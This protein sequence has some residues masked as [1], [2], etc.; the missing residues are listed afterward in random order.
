MKLLLILSSL[1]IF[2][3]I[4]SRH[5]ISRIRTLRE[6]NVNRYINKRRLQDD[7]M[8]SMS[9]DNP[10]R[11][12]FQ[13]FPEGL[14]STEPNNSLVSGVESEK[15]GLTS[16]IAVKELNI[17]ELTRTI[18]VLHN[19]IDDFSDNFMTQVTEISNVIN[20]ET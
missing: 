6:N 18:N 2:T 14:D 5:S 17:R 15:R 9:L 8:T 20:L 16:Q 1:S 12:G 13:T 4:I 19:S 7:S 10:E 3:S 11:K